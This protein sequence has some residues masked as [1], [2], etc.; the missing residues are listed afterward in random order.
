[1]TLGI[2]PGSYF[3]TLCVVGE[4]DVTLE[5]LPLRKKTKTGPAGEMLAITAI[6]TVLRDSVILTTIEPEVAWVEHG[7]GASRQSDF[8]LGAVFGATVATL[9]NRGLRV[10]QIHPSVWKKEVTAE[11]GMKTKAGEPGVGS[12]KKDVAN[13]CARKIAIRF[14]CRR[15]ISGVYDETVTWAH[16]T[17]DELDAFSVAWTAGRHAERGTVRR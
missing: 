8:I 17:P 7:F 14:N 10:E 6:P 16:L 2:D 1:M 15:I 4:R 13:A 11:C 5:T 9:S 12:V 3:L